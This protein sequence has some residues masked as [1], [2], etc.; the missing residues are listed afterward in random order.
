MKMAAPLTL[1]L[2][3]AVTVRA[4]LFRSSLTDL[5]AERVEVVSPITAWKRGKRAVAGMGGFD[6][7]TALRSMSSVTVVKTNRFSCSELKLS[8]TLK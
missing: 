4:A 3:V 5:I 7:G 1:L 2:I 6:A 8:V